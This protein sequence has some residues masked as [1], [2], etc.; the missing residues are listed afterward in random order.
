[1]EFW[2]LRVLLSSHPTG[3]FAC[4]HTSNCVDVCENDFSDQNQRG[5]IYLH[6]SA[7]WVKHYVKLLLHLF[8]QY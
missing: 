4:R 8:Q 3:I 5:K 6:N 2:V 1:M 7:K